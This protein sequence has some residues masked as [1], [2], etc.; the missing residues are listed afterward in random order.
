M[1][2]WE[3]LGYYTRARNLHK[4]AKMIADT[5][6]GVFPNTME[7]VRKL[8]GIGAYTAAAILSIAFDQPYPSM[9]GNL[10]RVFSRLYDVREYTDKEE[11]LGHLNNIAKA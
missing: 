7:E 9:D 3:G 10:I 11:T 2:A 4:A 1:K 8:P 6:G 5:L